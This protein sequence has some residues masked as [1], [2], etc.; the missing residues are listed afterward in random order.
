MNINRVA[1]IILEDIQ[2]EIDESEATRIHYEDAE[3]AALDQGY[4]D[5]LKEAKEIILKR[6]W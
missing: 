4:I 1:E 2:A 3:M 5:G 6:K